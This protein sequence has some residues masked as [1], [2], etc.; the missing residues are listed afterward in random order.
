MRCTTLPDTPFERADN[1]L[2]NECIHTQF[3]F[4]LALSEAANQ[5]R[6]FFACSDFVERENVFCRPC[7]AFKEA[8]FACDGT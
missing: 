5:S 6:R 2:S 3:P 8:S 4:Q 7:I 1:F